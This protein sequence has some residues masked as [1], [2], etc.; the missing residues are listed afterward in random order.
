MNKM[1]KLNL[2]LFLLVFVISL[3]TNN[4]FAQKVYIDINAG[5]GLKMS[6][7]NLDFMDF[8]NYTQK[9]NGYTE[10]QVN[11]SLGKGLFLGG[12]FGYM[13]NKNIG[14]ELD[15]S[16]L[17]GGK[18]KAKDTYNDG[19]KTD[20]AL[21]SKML[22]IIPTLVITPGFEKIN[23]Y[24]KIGLVIGSGS[25]LYEVKSSGDGSNEVM[26]IKFNGGI[27]LGLS[28]GIGATY[29]LSDKMSIFG[30]LNMVNL[31]YAPTKGKI[32][33]YTVNGVD[34][35]PSLTTSDK[36][37]EFVK[38]Y[39]YDSGN[40][41]SDSEPSQELKHKVPFGSFGVNVGWRISF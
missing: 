6:S 25:I 35:L 30:E 19:S 41:P 21:S 4:L 10:E 20:Y 15:L 27:A 13:F 1:K 37:I 8:Y 17:L 12:T 2:K 36:E 24:A 32:K 38:S 23:P 7:E 34:Q 5:Y 31:S 28:T 9:T 33:K 16:F 11:V 40:P 18:S 26:N 14:A 22:R 3:F 29:S 39:T